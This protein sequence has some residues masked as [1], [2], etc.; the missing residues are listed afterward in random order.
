MTNIA[1]LENE[2]DIRCRAAP[3]WNLNKTIQNCVVL[4]HLYYTIHSVRR[5]KRR[6]DRLQRFVRRDRSRHSG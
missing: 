4:P 6:W 1:P 2:P 3:K 5:N